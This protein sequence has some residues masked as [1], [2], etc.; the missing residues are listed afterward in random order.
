MPTDLAVSFPATTNGMVA[1]LERIEDTG[2]AWNLG[3]EI[4]AR[5]RII[6]EELMTNTIKYGY[7]RE[8]D[9]PIRLSLCAGPVPTLTYEDDAPPFDPTRWRP[10]NEDASPE[11]GPEGQ[12]GIKMVLGLSSSAAYRPRPDGNCLVLTLGALPPHQ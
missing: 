2:A 1:A 5:L 6:V 4:I 12:A 3:A 9:R 10:A 8:C 7:G 11:D